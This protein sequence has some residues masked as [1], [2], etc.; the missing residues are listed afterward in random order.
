M[1]DGDKLISNQHELENHI[2]TFYQTLR[3]RDEHVESIEDARQNCFQYI[4][5]IVTES[6]NR[7]LSKPL[8]MEEVS[9][10]MKQL[11]AGKT[12]RIDTIPAEFYQELWE[13]IEFDIFNFVLQSINQATI[14]DELNVSKIALLPKSK[15][16][17]QIQ[18]SQPI[19]FLNT[20]HKIVAKVYANRMKSLL[21]HW[22][23]PFQTCFVSNRCILNN[24]FLEFEAIE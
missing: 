3:T 6:H 9:A 8:T 15:D 19:S 23:L 12:P 18:N 22:I 24:I 10:A 1:M 11:P 16:R 14:M 7:E 2:L 13:D 21:H 5:Q 4:K 20:L 17:M